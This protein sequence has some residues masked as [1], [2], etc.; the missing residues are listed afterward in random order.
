VAETLGAIA[1]HD[2][3][4]VFVYGSRSRTFD[5]TVH[6]GREYRVLSDAVGS[7]PFGYA[8]GLYDAETGLVRFGARDYDAALGRW[9]TKDPILFAGGDPNV[10]GYVGNDPV[11]RV[12]PEGLFAPVVG[13]CVFWG[14]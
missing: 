3:S 8:G 1:S 11:N 7:V 4:S 13:V 6:G 9:T 2:E 10:Y 12:D 14:L 5:Y